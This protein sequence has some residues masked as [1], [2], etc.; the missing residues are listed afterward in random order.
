MQQLSVS[1]DGRECQAR[2]GH[3]RGA[4]VGDPSASDF[5]PLIEFNV[6]LCRIVRLSDWLLPIKNL[7]LKP[8]ADDFGVT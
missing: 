3:R 7:N 1:L 4:M 5:R 6:E 2:R 8:F